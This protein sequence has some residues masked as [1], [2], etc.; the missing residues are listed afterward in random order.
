M[1]WE[2]WAVY[3]KTGEGGR[4]WGKSFY[5]VPKA[6]TWIPERMRVRC[7]WCCWVAIGRTEHPV[8]SQLWL[9][10]CLKPSSVSEMWMSVRS[11]CVV[12]RLLIMLLWWIKQ[13]LKFQTV[14]FAAQALLPLRDACKWRESYHWGISKVPF[15]APAVSKIL[16]DFITKTGWKCL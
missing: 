5:P 13:P 6:I 7:R 11:T 3:H 12:Y 15:A 9:L 14:Y 16:I 10:L 8:L 4:L 2:Q 1:C